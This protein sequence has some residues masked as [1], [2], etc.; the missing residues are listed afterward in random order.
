MSELTYQELKDA[1]DGDVVAI[2]ALGVNSASRINPAGIEKTAFAFLGRRQPP[3]PLRLA[4]PRG[5]RESEGP[6]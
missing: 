1:V 5:P 4:G 3:T 6:R 2:R